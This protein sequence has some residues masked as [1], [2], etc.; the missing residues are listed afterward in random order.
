MPTLNFLSGLITQIILLGKQ[1]LSHQIPHLDDLLWVWKLNKVEY[2]ILGIEMTRDFQII[3]S[4]D[5]I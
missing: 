5:R 1:G 2:D 4:S 3:F